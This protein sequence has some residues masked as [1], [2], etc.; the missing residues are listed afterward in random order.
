MVRI[1]KT[2]HKRDRYVTKTTRGETIMKNTKVAKAL[3]PFML[4]GSPAIAGG[5]SVRSG[6]R[7]KVKKAV[8]QSSVKAQPL[9]AQK[10]EFKNPFGVFGS[11]KTTIKKT[12]DSQSDVLA[13]LN[14][15]GL[16]DTKGI[17][18]NLQSGN[19]KR[20][21]GALATYSANP[22]L[23]G[24]QNFYLYS[25]YCYIA[26]ASTIYVPMAC[27]TGVC[28]AG[29]DTDAPTVSGIT[30][31]GSPSASDAS[32]SFSVD[33]SENIKNVDTGD[34]ELTT[35]GD[36]TGTIA[37]VSS[38]TGDPITV[39]VNSISGTGTIRLDIK[40]THNIK[41]DA[42]NALSGGY[43]S[44][45]VHNVEPANATPE[46]T[47]PSA[48]TV[49]EDDTN[50]AFADTIHITDTDGHNQAVTLTATNGTLSM[51]A[52]GTTFTTGDGT[53]DAVLAFNGTLTNV[54][55]ALDTLTF[56][57]TANF[58]GTATLRMQ[59]DDS[60]GGT[61][62]DT[63]T[64][65]TVT[66]VNDAP[67]DITL[68]SSS[69]AQSGGANA[70]VGTLGVAD[71]DTGDTATY[72]LVAGTD[73]ANNGSFNISGTS[74]RADDSGALAAGTYKI[75]LNVYDGDANYEKAFTITVTD[76]VAPTAS[77]LSPADNAT[78]ITTLY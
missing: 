18:Q 70:S 27:C 78:N 62:D 69:V 47:L 15:E 20:F 13:F 40:T 4:L 29:G 21:S 73:D 46:N 8:V 51:T 16:L 76:D 64:P 48:P 44:G 12:K 56:T 72:S 50:V 36:A 25:G 34:F 53:D 61:D 63:L 41:D 9:V 43:T 55:T 24:G 10:K 37:S 39:T 1:F 5:S 22:V 11:S 77:S 75:R 19:R 68:T 35:T 30:I 28:P 17:S 58:N 42:D 26:P 14:E 38:T 45:A 60:N 52:S 7:F 67:T 71:A 57:P 3:L 49:A 23:T 66:E 6:S 33:F 54:N 59:T 2:K 32:V 74:L 31:S 65:I